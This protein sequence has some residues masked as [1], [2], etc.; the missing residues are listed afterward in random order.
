MYTLLESISNMIE[1]FQQYSN[2]DK[3]EGTLSKRE[4]LKELRN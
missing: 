4:Q 1:I 3:E 2:N